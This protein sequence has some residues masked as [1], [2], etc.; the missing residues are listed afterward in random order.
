MEEIKDIDAFYQEQRVRYPAALGS[1]TCDL[2]C[3]TKPRNPFSADTVFGVDITDVGISN[4]VQSDLSQSP[5]P[6]ENGS[7]DYITAFDFIEHVP[8]IINLPTIRLSFIELMNEIHRVLKPK[9]IFL[10]QTPVYPF[11]AC[12]TDPTHI[13]P[14]TSETFSLYFDDQ[15]KWGA[16]YGFKGSFRIQKQVLF[17]THLLTVLQKT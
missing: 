12:F 6:F 14:V 3:G 4:I 11:S 10:A 15:R 9:G 1:K 16:M 5:I 17:A 2:G 13:N 8:R 7:M